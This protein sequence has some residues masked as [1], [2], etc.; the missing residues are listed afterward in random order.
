MDCVFEGQ[1]QELAISE[2]SIGVSTKASVHVGPRDAERRKELAEIE[3]RIQRAAAA[4]SFDAVYVD[5]CISAAEISRSLELPRV[6]VE[7]RFKRAERAANKWGNRHQKIEVVYQLIR[8]LYYWYN[9]FE[10]IPDL[11][12]RLEELVEGT[13]SAHNLE[14]LSNHWFAILT[15]SRMDDPIVATEWLEARTEFIIKESTRLS[16]ETDRPSNALQAKSIGL[17]T[18]L[19]LC[20]DSPDPILRELRS[21]IE[22][23]KGLVGFPARRFLDL[24]IELGP[25]IGKASEYDGLF[26][27]AVKMASEL[28]GELTT[29]K[30]LLRRGREH[31][32]NSRASDAIRVLGRTLRLLYRFDSRHLLMGALYSIGQAYSEVGLLWAARGAVLT[33]ASITSNDFYA[34]GQITSAQSAC[35]DQMKWL[36]LCLGRIPS[37]LEWHELDLAVKDVLAR[38]NNELPEHHEIDFD[39]LMGKQILRLR[40]DSLRYMTF[41]ESELER[42]ALPLSSKALRYALGYED[43]LPEEMFGEEVQDPQLAFVR[44]R[45]L[46]ANINVDRQ[47]SVGEAARQTLTSTILGCHITAVTDGHPACNAFAET[48]LACLESLLATSMKARVLPLAPALDIEIS[49]SDSIGKCIN[50]SY[51]DVNGRAKYNAICGDINPYNPGKDLLGEIQDVLADSVVSILAHSFLIGDLESH[52][53]KLFKDESALE[54]AINYNLSFSHV[55]NVLGHAPKANLM[56][57][58]RPD[59]VDLPLLRNEDWDTGNASLTSPRVESLRPGVGEVPGELF[60]ESE[61]SH[62]DFQASAVVRIPLWDKAGWF[63][64]G[65]IFNPYRPEPPILALIFKNRDVARTI[66]EEWKTEFG[67]R[68]LNEI[69]VSI[70]TGVDVDNPTYYRVSIGANLESVSSKGRFFTLI[71]RSI[72]M[73]PQS[74]MNLDNFLT[75]Y[76]HTKSFLLAPAVMDDER[77]GPELLHKSMIPMKELHVRQAWEIGP[78]DVDSPSVHEDDNPIIPEGISEPPFIELIKQRKKRI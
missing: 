2:L 14:L 67:D 31:L 54:R 70:I 36:E 53:E 75:V 47:P 6:E 64:I 49:H 22:S 20:T 19:I 10:D 12:L 58:R 34:F 41:M 42:L 25:R 32:S 33:G 63:A 18:Q 59:S 52:L 26:E 3:D 74:S 40:L 51:A 55:G 50:F 73:T 48:L 60:D 30:Y 68:A 76:S 39:V 28:D 16:G 69:R 61:M 8:T 11:Y 78:H 7:G 17:L 57:W 66:F 37:A 29:A 71:S 45:D 35:Y 62:T 46:T 1:F 15:L 44:W 38:Q 43:D 23:S 56:Q 13:D 72:T 21:V 77:N 65:F 27:S 5:D 24:I 9:D 4:N